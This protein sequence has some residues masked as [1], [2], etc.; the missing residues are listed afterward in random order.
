[1]G[2]NVL[3]Y[4]FILICLA[5]TPAF[6]AHPLDKYLFIRNE[7]QWSAD[8]L[9][10][11]D[12]PGG[13]LCITT[14]GLQY[15]MYDAGQTGHIHERSQD[16]KLRTGASGIQT[17][18]VS[19]KFEG[20][21]SQ[22]RIK[23]SLPEEQTFNFFLG[24]DASQWRTGVKAYREIYISGVFRNVDFRLYSI[25]QSL[26]Y[27]YIVKPG[28]NPA[29]IKLDYEGVTDKKLSG[30]DLVMN[31][32]FST[33][34]EF[35]PFS[36]QETGGKKKEVRSSF[37]MDSGR[38]SFDIGDYDSSKDLIIDPELVFSSYSGSV[39]DNWS[40]TATYD[41]E[42]NLYAAGTVFGPNFSVT[43]G[44]FQDHFGGG[45]G[46]SGVILRTD[47]VII[48]YAE[49]GSRI[50]YSTFL[51]G[52]ESE[53]PHSMIVNSK[54]QLVVFGT[55]SSLNF[56]VTEQAYD[57]TFNGGVTVSD[58]Q[59]TTGIFY[60]L[61]SDIFV[62]VISPDGTKLEGSTFMGGSGNDGLHD[63][64]VLSIRN[65]GDEFR[66][67]VYVDKEDRIY[68]ASV[69]TSE[70]FPQTGPASPIHS[71][72]DAVVFRLN[73]NCSKLEFS[74]FLGG[75][76]YDAA[77][78]V[79]A[80][81]K[82]DIYVCG[83][84]KSRD[85]GTTPGAHR[86]EFG[87][88]MEG[89]IVKISDDK[90][91]VRTYLGTSGADIA[92]L[93]DLDREGNVYVFG[94]TNGSYPVSSGVYSNARSGQ[95]IHCLD[96]QLS[97]T[98]FS[99]VFGTGRGNGR[100]DI[101]PTAFMV[102]DCGNIY[103]AGWGGKVNSV[104]GYNPNSTTTGLPVTR[105]AFQSSTT[106][107]NY[108]LAIFERNFKSLIFGTFF[109]S[110]APPQAQDERGDHLDGGT[111]RFDKNG[112]I[113]HSA[114][115][116][117]AGSFVQ[118][119]VKNAA[120][121]SHNS[122]NCNMAAFKFNIDALLA[123]FDLESGSL[124][125]M[126]EVCAP[127]KIDLVNKSVG[128]ISYRWKIN[129]EVISTAEKISYTFT[130][131]GNY[132]I[133]LI[134]YNNLL[135]KAA[136]STVR[137]LLVKYFESA[138][139]NDT[140]VCQGGKVLLKASGGISYHWTPSA[141]LSDP[142]IPDPVASVQNST[143]FEVS[144]SNGA[145]T[146][147]REVNVKV[148]NTKKDFGVTNSTTICA[149]K[150]LTLYASGLAEHFVWSAE[151]MSDSTAGSISIMPAKTTVYTVTGIYADGCRPEKSIVISID[152]SVKPDF[153]LLQEFECN[154]PVIVSLENKTDGPAV[155]YQWEIDSGER[156]N[157]ADIRNFQ[158]N[159]ERI[160]QITLKAFSAQGCEFALTKDLDIRKWDGIIPN[161]ITPNGDGKND[162]FVIGFPEIKLQ[163]YDAW[164]RII[165]NSE[166]YRNDWGKNVH[167]G[168]YY[169]LLNLPDGKPC[170]GW[171]Q[172]I[173]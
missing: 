85:F 10:K 8:I 95:F 113:Y 139:S 58:L 125:N 83:V 105:D 144:I 66:G 160:H 140:V 33:L 138:V 120:Q 157:S 60:L 39:S 34:K 162:T 166:N 38:I 18:T 24:N 17:R 43:P 146:V 135:C 137:P 32:G 42:G 148:E 141:G 82:G 106:G 54:G 159:G 77:Y 123:R 72:Y 57:R 7:G 19:Y 25:D 27:E 28:G 99:S 122:T 26:K 171:L 76:D 110:S 79:R 30:G 168:N 40:H 86:T 87:G 112:I 29:E 118:F 49:D 149:G 13:Y 55:T 41:A 143:V 59:N 164:G 44:V 35:A 80:N 5:L 161:V 21:V 127:A 151:G 2:R 98:L 53:V 93:M 36:Y 62:T 68:V 12:I 74:T 50:L 48:K 101:V 84:S 130:D 115:V 100:I 63:Y 126:S 108:Y 92:V 116:C 31:T 111:C 156:F 133:K 145:C 173:K 96:S 65:Y 158:V 129:E 152:N 37:K 47:I 4:I 61:G 169:Y 104:N 94:L 15:L 67:E 6:A 78:A 23:A 155:N 56:P 75:S 136:D 142:D 11:A 45:S 124:R 90:V 3:Q 89:F 117:K 128:A 1:M 52:Q 14:A 97:R 51:G 165:L 172:V 9:Y 119:P 131:S 170:K 163:I 16:N 114:C 153:E 81:D 132:S 134:A 150:R 167:P 147:K 109:G 88:D 91:T 20:A 102:N 64:R 73:A 71:F 69:T 103:V 107:S 22:A 46:G 154:R 121:P 70:N